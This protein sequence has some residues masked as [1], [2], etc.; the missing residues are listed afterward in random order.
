M[1]VLVRNRLRRPVLSTYRF[2]TVAK[3]ILASAGDPH[4][5]LSVEL[6]GDRRMRRLNRQYRGLDRPTDVLAFPMRVGLC[7]ASS[8]LGDVV[9]SVHTADRQARA[10]GHSLDHELITLLVH[11]ILHLLGYDHE[12]SRREADRMVRK[13]RAIL[14][15]LHL[16]PS[17]LTRPA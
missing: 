2:Q 6:V 14:S 4:A 11:G 17:L 5:D 1:P 15:Y 13:E 7:P 16:S 9:I 8:L 3:R 10:A 12:R